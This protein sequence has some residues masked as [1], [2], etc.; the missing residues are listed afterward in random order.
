MAAHPLTFPVYT[1]IPKE[2]GE[3]YKMFG[4]PQTVV[5]LPKAQ[6]IRNWVG[7]YAGNQRSE[8][9][10]YFHLTLPGLRPRISD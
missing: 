3:A 8:I 4:T 10:A 2:L 5:V 7:A 9:E 1:D 6:V